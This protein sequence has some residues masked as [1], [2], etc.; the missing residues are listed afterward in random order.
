MNL[1]KTRSY[2]LLAT[3]LL[4]TALFVT[5]LILFSGPI[6][7]LITIGTV[8]AGAIMLR[9][10]G[11]LFDFLDRKQT[12]QDFNLQDADSHYKNT[13]YRY[14]RFS[15]WDLTIVPILYRGLCFVVN[16]YLGRLLS[17]AILPAQIMYPHYMSDHP[18][19]RDQS[20]DPFLNALKDRSVFGHTFADTSR[21]YVETEDGAL[22]DTIHTKVSDRDRLDKTVIIMGGN[23]TS[24]LCGYLPD[25]SQSF[26]QDG[27]DVINFSFRGVEFSTGTPHHKHDLIKDGI[28]QVA[29]LLDDGM[30][31]EDICLY[32]HSLGGGTALEVA[33]YFQQRGQNIKVFNDRSFDR[34]SDVIPEKLFNAIRATKSWISKGLLGALA[35]IIKGVTELFIPLTEWQFSSAKIS[36]NLKP[37]TFNY[38]VCREHRNHQDEVIA[39]YASIHHAL[40][41]DRQEENQRV[42]QLLADHHID[43]KEIESLLYQA[44]RKPRL[45]G[46][47]STLDYVLNKYQAKHLTLSGYSLSSALSAISDFSAV[48]YMRHARKT[49]QEH[50]TPLYSYARNQNYQQPIEHVMT[51]FEGGYDKSEIDAIKERAVSRVVAPAA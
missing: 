15:W 38:A 26:L 10:H 22:L 45:N 4:I 19:K 42:K 25:V 12:K 13:R 29:R 48:H 47:E 23:G 20:R 7:A 16:A 24:L 34:I 6:G 43:N 39:H 8:I 17:Y 40:K 27:F 44:S 33:H 49:T 28:A 32:G 14:S 51:F 11:A 2:A 31:A 46:F 21:F 36:K 5:S 30:A 9:A 18:P 35:L 3:L 50:M 37:D 41:R 1:K